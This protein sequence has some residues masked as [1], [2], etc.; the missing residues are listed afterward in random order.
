MNNNNIDVNNY[1]KLLE[2]HNKHK[3]SM[4]KWAKNNKIKIS[5]Y[6]KQYY[7]DV[8]TPK[9]INNDI[10]I[11]IRISQRKA[12]TKYYTKQK[13]LRAINTVLYPIIDH[14]IL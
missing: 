8:L 6:R 14:I 2:Q 3:I 12:S 10:N 13:E 5:E 9:I 4:Q 1:N 11:N 7:A